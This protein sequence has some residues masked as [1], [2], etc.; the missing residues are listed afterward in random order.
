MDARCVDAQTPE[1][2]FRQRFPECVCRLGD[3]APGWGDAGV[4]VP[5]TA[6][7]QYGDKAILEE[8]WHAMQRWMNFIQTDNP[9]FLRNNRLGA[10]FRR[11]AA[12]RQPNP[13][14]PGRHRLLGPDG[15]H[16]GA[17]GARHR[18]RGRREALSTSCRHTFAPPFRKNTS[19]TTAQ[20]ATAARLLTC[21]RCI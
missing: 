16:D 14:G 20:W 8:N 15:A 19:R 13:Q 18:Q 21:W 17:D 2:A 3:G 5:W 10:E 9:N 1:G 4:I 6:W 11:L 12:G 7:M